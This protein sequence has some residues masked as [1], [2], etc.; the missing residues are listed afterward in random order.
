M[1]TKFASKK[2]PLLYSGGLKPVLIM[3]HRNLHLA[4][5]SRIFRVLSDFVFLGH[6]IIILHF[7]QTSLY[8]THF[9]FRMCYSTRFLLVSKSVNK[10]NKTIINPHVTLPFFNVL[11]SWCA[12]IYLYLY[13]PDA[14]MYNSTVFECHRLSLMSHI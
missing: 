8:L 13:S 11:K 5:R 12:R 3:H 4:I 2:A 9:Y 10:L 1:A 7:F 6:I 14:L